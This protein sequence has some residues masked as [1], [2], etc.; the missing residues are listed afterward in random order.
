MKA[1]ELREAS[2]P[3]R[4][5]EPTRIEDRDV[6][7]DSMSVLVAADVARRA[8]EVRDAACEAADELPA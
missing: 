8:D 7:V 1:V 5:G 6:P 2:H 4:L 3:G